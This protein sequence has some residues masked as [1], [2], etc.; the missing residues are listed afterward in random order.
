M[1][2]EGTQSVRGTKLCP[3]W[4]NLEI[5]RQYNDFHG[6]WALRAGRFHGF[7]LSGAAKDLQL[8]PE[9]DVKYLWLSKQLCLWAQ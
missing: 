3:I 4:R 6:F 7:G 2:A 9:A 8:G 5:K 1:S